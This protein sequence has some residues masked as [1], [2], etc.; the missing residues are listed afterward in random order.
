M[1]HVY[2]YQICNVFHVP[3]LILLE[4]GMVAMSCGAGQ[5]K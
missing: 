1:A 4:Q 5:V 3:A 2:L